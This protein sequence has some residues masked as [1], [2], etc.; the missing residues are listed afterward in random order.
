MVSLYIRMLKL[1]IDEDPSI[2]AVISIML[3]K[4]NQL[5]KHFLTKSTQA[6]DLSIYRSKVS[7]ENYEALVTL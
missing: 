2:I 4:V 7:D 3:S 1:L 6:N 5:N